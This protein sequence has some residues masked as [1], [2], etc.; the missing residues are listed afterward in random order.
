M[1]DPNIKDFYDRI[2]RLQKAHARGEGFEAPG[3]LGR[4]YYY[5]KPKKR[6]MKMVLPMVF[7]AMSVFGL[8]GAIHYQIG[9]QTYESRV[10]QLNKGEGFDRLGSVLMSADPV[11]L[12]V[13][14]T[15]RKHIPSRV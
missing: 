12:W 3:T 14:G 10:S 8:K 4:S 7:V 9:A 13:S 1:H 11:T 6:P 2:G 15:L 5:R